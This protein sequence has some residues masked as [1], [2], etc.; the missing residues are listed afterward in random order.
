MIDRQAQVQELI[1]RVH[2]DGS[3]SHSAVVTFDEAGC[4]TV[5]LS[6]EEHDAVEAA[7][8]AKR[9]FIV[10][11]RIAA[12]DLQELATRDTEGGP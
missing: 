3:V 11:L 1:R 12:P 2:R 8:L 7:M 10:T 9:R 5:R 6:R 4:S